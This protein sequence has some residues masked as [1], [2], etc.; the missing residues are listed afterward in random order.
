MR[1]LV[2]AAIVL[3]GACGTDAVSLDDYPDAFHDAFCRHLV[4]CGD[5]ERADTCKKLNLGLDFRLSASTTAAADMGKITYSGENAQKCLDAFAARSCDVTSQS[6]RVLP[7]AC[8]EIAIGTEHDGAAC[9]QDAECLSQV[10][11]VPACTMACCTGTC[12]GDTAPGVAKAGESCANAV[13]DDTSFCDNAVMMCVALKPADAFCTSPRECAYGLDCLQT[14]VCGALPGPGDA[15]TGP[16]R[17]EGTTCSPTSRTCVKVA[18]GG[19]ACT[20]SAD[21]SPL[22]TCD[23]TKHCSAGPALGA[24]CTIGQRCG[25]DRAFCDV[26]AGQAM[27]TCVLPKANG[28][29]CQRNSDCDS[30]SCDPATL[31]CG[32]E[33]ICL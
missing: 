28:A 12:T 23:A 19:A 9:A 13:C 33:P 15:C 21:C 14:G 25:T 17:D 1:T 4:K 29:P 30:Q 22:Y 24:A 7:E 32:P 31:V 26:P 11:D 20:T 5:V 6:G 2:I 27:G 16:C 18:L 10:C 8:R 3:F